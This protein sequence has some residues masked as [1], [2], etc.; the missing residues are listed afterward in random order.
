MRYFRVFLLYLGK[1][2][3]LTQFYL[4]VSGECFSHDL[5]IRGIA[6]VFSS[7]KQQSLQVLPVDSFDHKKPESQWEKIRA[8][9]GWF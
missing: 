7:G 9:G 6:V 2:N 1:N 5:K 3:N 8:G 4:S